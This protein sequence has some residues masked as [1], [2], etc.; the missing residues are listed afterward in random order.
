M[1]RLG[2]TI[3]YDGTDF[4]GWQSQPERRTVQ[5]EMETALERLSGRRIVVTGSGRTDAGVHA[6]G[7]YAHV[8]VDDSELD[9]VRKG[10]DRLLP[11][12]VAIRMIERVEQDFHARFSAKQVRAPAAQ[13]LA[14][15]SGNGEGRRDVHR[16]P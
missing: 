14:R 5:G 4:S 6:I 10:L 15:C 13:R 3:E 7:Q 8:D 1:I 16:K 11:D 2:L 12:D 9:R